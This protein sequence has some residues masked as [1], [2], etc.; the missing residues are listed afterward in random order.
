[1]Y[2]MGRLVYEIETRHLRWQ[3]ASKTPPNLWTPPN[4]PFKGRDKGVSGTSLG[5]GRPLLA[6]PSRGGIEGC[7]D[8][9]RGGIE[10]R[11]VRQGREN[12]S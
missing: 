5:E 4:L 1:M 9:D 11:E 6:S 10:K 2:E 8:S 12:P 3:V 7:P